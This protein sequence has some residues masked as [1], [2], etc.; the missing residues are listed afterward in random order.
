M[1]CYFYILYSQ[2]LDKYY[3]GHT[4]DILEDRLRRHLSNHKGFTGKLKTIQNTAAYST[5]LNINLSTL[6]L[7]PPFHRQSTSRI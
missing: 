3:L 6:K 4:C 7:P 5:S 1:T 2:T